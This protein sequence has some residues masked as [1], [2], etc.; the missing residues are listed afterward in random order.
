MTADRPRR[1]ALSVGQR[2]FLGLLP[3]LLAVLLVVGLAYY[4]QYART[5]P[6]AVVLAAAALALASL[7]VTWLNTRYLTGRIARLADSIPVRRAAAETAP[8]SGDELDRI[9]QEVDRLDSALSA[10]EAQRARADAAA[11]AALREQATLVAATVRDAVAQLDEVRLPL[12]ILLESRFGELNENQEELLRDA[13]AAADEMDGALRRLAH[14]A[15]ADRGALRVQREL[16]RV[17]DVVRAVL[18]MARSAAATKGLTVDVSLDPTVPRVRADRARLAEALSLLLDAAVARQDGGTLRVTTERVDGGAVL[19]RLAGAG[20]GDATRDA[21]ART[22]AGR[23]V[24]AQGG[25]VAE[26]GGEVTIRLG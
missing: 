10:S 7:L 2:L 20:P 3:S 22:L 15:D 21:A 8:R 13:R 25:V 18:P 11:A 16:V 14:V 1:G 12:H 24:A 5:V 26:E 23:L 9:E 19:V 17:N 4:G 6:V